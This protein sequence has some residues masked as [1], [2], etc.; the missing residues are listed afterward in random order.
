[1]G[2]QGLLRGQVCHVH[3]KRSERH[4]NGWEGKEFMIGFESSHAVPTRLSGRG[5]SI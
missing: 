5:K 3:L 1:M 4:Y 2:L